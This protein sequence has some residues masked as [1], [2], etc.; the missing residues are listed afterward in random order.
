MGL[1]ELTQQNYKAEVLDS[2][3]PVVIKFYDQNCDV[4]KL[5]APVLEKVSADYVNK[6]KFANC[7]RL[8]NSEIA[9]KY[10]ANYA[11]Q[12]VV[13]YKDK[14]LGL[15]PGALIS[16]TKHLAAKEDYLRNNINKYLESIVKQ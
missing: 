13:A 11:S 7:D 14:K 3:L 4:C 6:A 2:N 16:G 5:L 10:G 9:R 1:I 12:I 8:R 15:F